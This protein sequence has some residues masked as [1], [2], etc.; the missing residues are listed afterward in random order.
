MLF[1]T[2]LMAK[3]DKLSSQIV[4]KKDFE[5]K[6]T[7][8]SQM[9]HV[10]KLLSSQDDF[11]TIKQLKNLGLVI[12]FEANK[13]NY[14]LLIPDMNKLWN[15]Y[16]LQPQQQRFGDS[17]LRGMNK[18]NADKLLLTLY[19]L[20]E[21]LKNKLGYPGHELSEAIPALLKKIKINNASFNH[22][23]LRIYTGS[24]SKQFS[25]VQKILNRKD[26][27]F[28]QKLEEWI[29]RKYFVRDTEGYISSVDARVD[30]PQFLTVF[31]ARIEKLP[32]RRF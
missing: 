28:P 21:S 11:L 3:L 6:K 32:K 25:V 17:L 14:A 13:E 22:E 18:V 9:S 16:Y 20:D 1:N 15:R 24:Y 2:K 26:I 19:R 31:V 29:G 23:P 5:H 8:I 10:V 27:I 4:S 30:G 12:S 7:L